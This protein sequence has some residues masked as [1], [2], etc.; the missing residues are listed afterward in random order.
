[1]AGRT[2]TLHGGLGS[3]IG[4]EEHRSQ[5]TASADD[6][7]FCG[8]GFP[9]QC[10]WWTPAQVIGGGIGHLNCAHSQWSVSGDLFIQYIASSC[11]LP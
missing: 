2:G 4:T 10:T 6:G 5:T 3:H 9:G 7:P 1:M 11:S 8:C